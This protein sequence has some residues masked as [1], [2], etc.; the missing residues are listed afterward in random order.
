MHVSVSG[1]KG[2]GKMARAARYVCFSQSGI[3]NHPNQDK[4]EPPDRSPGMCDSVLHDRVCVC[5]RGRKD[6]ARHQSN[7]ALALSPLVAGLW[8]APL[9]A[10]GP[11]HSAHVIAFRERPRRPCGRMGKLLGRGEGDGE[12]MV[13]MIVGGRVHIISDGDRA[14]IQG[15]RVEDRRMEE[16]AAMESE[17]VIGGLMG[18]TCGRD[19]KGK[20]QVL[21]GG[22]GSNE[23]QGLVGEMEL[24]MDRRTRLLRVTSHTR[25]GISGDD[26]MMELER[27]SLGGGLVVRA[28]GDDWKMVPENNEGEIGIGGVIKVVE[29]KRRCFD[30]GEYSNEQRKRLACFPKA[31]PGS[32]NISRNRQGLNRKLQASERFS[33]VLFLIAARRTGLRV[34][35]WGARHLP[36][37]SHRWGLPAATSAESLRWGRAAEGALL[38]ASVSWFSFTAQGE[39]VGDAPGISFSSPP[40]TGAGLSH[41]HRSGDGHA[42]RYAIK[43]CRCEGTKHTRVEKKREKQNREIREKGSGG[44]S[45][46]GRS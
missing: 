6:R 23:G 11:A 18:R 46:S 21:E 24:A 8:L 37:L 34:Q 27:N 2:E 38:E 19:K 33:K 35:F 5:V 26:W 44:I 42:Q 16:E 17:V 3:S 28:S 40:L 30:G 9:P 4:L 1:C 43:D 45:H 20:L 31:P 25:G 7:G 10:S 32:A 14:D 29:W 36:Q 41:C 22:E 12:R 13:M 39:E 15:D